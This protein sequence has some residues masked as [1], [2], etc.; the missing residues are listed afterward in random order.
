M[1]KW[2]NISQEDLEHW[3]D[4]PESRTEFPRLVRKLITETGK[5]VSFIRMASGSGVATGGFDGVVEA[6]TKTAFVPSGKSV[7]ELSVGDDLKRKAD[8]DYQKR[9]EKP[10]EGVLLAE[11]TYVQVILRRWGA[12]EDW[13][14]ERR[15][16]GK[17]RDVIAL[18]IDDLQEWLDQAPAASAW[19]AEVIGI[20]TEGVTTASSWWK[21]WLNSTTFRI[22]A[23]VVLGGREGQARKL[24][25]RIHSGSGTS[26]IGGDV[27]IDEI[28]AFLSA[29]VE[30]VEGDGSGEQEILFVAE[31][32]TFH[33]LLRRHE[34]LCLF[35]PDPAYLKN[36]SNTGNHHVLI[37][38][39]G[40]RRDNGHRVV[41]PSIDEQ[42]V[43]EIL[44]SQGQPE[45]K[46]REWGFLAR[47]SLL[48]LQ[49]HL[50]HEPHV[51]RPSWATEA[52]PPLRRAL[53]LHSWN[54][55]AAKDR[56]VVA[57]L[58]G[59]RYSEIEEE[60]TARAHE[61]ED[62]LL[63]LTD[64]MWH[65]VSPLDAW[66]LL[67][68]HLSENDLLDFRGAVMTVLGECDPALDIPIEDRWKANLHGASRS[69]SVDLGDGLARSLALLGTTNPRFS[70]PSGTG[71]AWAGRIVGRLLDR[72]NADSSF[73]LW[74]SLSRWLDRKSVV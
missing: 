56:E 6:E 43:T 68:P 25:D 27:R 46:A 11:T 35:I 64:G 71:E 58:I 20:P 63:A 66:E 62:P 2:P 54:R 67:G 42:R 31:P 8:S 49:R 73:G 15:G 9:T 41:L 47:R 61:Q 4:S 34:P 48:A 12:R 1:R 18:G 44:E 52:I 36:I 37:A 59:C 55:T 38:V 33:K 7:W 40:D 69:C 29:A 23:D 32:K 26:V 50:A 13:A 72:A 53:L 16:E 70:G 5:G 17:W 10:I 65:V 45:E 39:P 21:G 60:F 19:L 24:L 14:S 51:Y 3:A 22:S 30:S 74:T 57:E 28:R